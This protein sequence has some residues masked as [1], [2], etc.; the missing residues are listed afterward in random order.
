MID[1]LEKSDI[2]KLYCKNPKNTNCIK[3]VDGYLYTNNKELEQQVDLEV[4]TAETTNVKEL[5]SELPQSTN[6]TDNYASKVVTEEIENIIIKGDND[7][8]IIDSNPKTEKQQEEENK[9]IKY[10]K[11]GYDRLPFALLN[12]A[13]L[14][15]RP[16]DYTE[17]MI[18]LYKNLILE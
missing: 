3:L 7:A 15:D 10:A 1:F 8:I 4:A 2:L 16:S 6:V 11:N 12:D 14:T 17:F 18:K 13:L 9:Y 5:Q